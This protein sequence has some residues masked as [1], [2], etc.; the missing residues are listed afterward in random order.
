MNPPFYQ[1]RF[2]LIAA[3][4]FILL[5]GATNPRVRA[6]EI[7]DAKKALAKG[8]YAEAAKL[9]LTAIEQ[10]QY[11]EEPRVV[12]ASALLAVGKYP[13]AQAA[14]SNALTRIHSG[15]RVRLTG[16]EVYRQNGDTNRANELLREINQ[17]AGSRSWAY[18]DPANF[19]ALGRAALLLGADPKVVLEKV[20]DQAKKI[21]ASFR[22]TYLASGELALDKHDYE[23]AAKTFDEAL[24]KFPQDAELLFGL[25][26]AYE[27]SNR[28][29]MLKA[30]TSALD[31]NPR[32]VPSLLLIVEHMID[33]ENYDE[34]LKKLDEIFKINPWQPDAWA[35]ASVI[36]HLRSDAPGEKDSRDKALKFW[37][38]NPRVENLIGKK[39]SQKY[40]FAEGAAHQRQ[41]LKFDDDFVPARIQLAQDLLRL[42]DEA[43]GWKLVKEASDADAY[44]VETFNLLT[45]KDSIAKFASVTNENF[46]IR[47]TRHEADIYGARALA[48]LSRARTN[49]SAKYGL[50]LT[51]P[52]IVEIFPSQ[53]DFGVRTFGMP[54]NPGY[55]GVCFGRVITANSPASQGGHPA[56]W[57]A[58]L[59]HE[60]CHVIT[61]TLTKNKMPRWLSEGI[62]VYEE[63]Q[64]NPAWG[65]KMTA[66]FR[67]IIL[68]GK[69]KPIGE[70]SAAFLTAKSNQQLQFAYFESSLAVE[71]LVKKFGAEAI[72]KILV[73]L[74]NGVEINQAI[75]KNTA[76]L[77]NT[78][79]EFADFL[80]E[81]ADQL[82]PGLD[83]E[84]P[85]RAELRGDGLDLP[86]I[87][88]LDDSDSP[89]KSKE[90]DRYGNGP[91]LTIPK[92]GLSPA[93]T[94][95][96]KQHP[97]NFYAL[98]LQADQL[99][100]DKKLAEAKQ[101]LN[102][103]IELYP[104]H[105]GPNNAYTLLADIH[106]ELNETNAEREVLSRLAVL[107]ADAADTFLRLMDLGAGAKNWDL[108]S[109][110]AERFIAVNPLV[111]RPYRYL[112][113]A[114]EEL[115]NPPAAIYAYQTLLRL[116]PNDPAEIHFHL[117]KLLHGRDEAA[118]RR[119]ILQTLEEAPRFRDGH[120][121]LLEIEKAAPAP[122]SATNGFPLF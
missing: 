36:R 109:T 8:N 75:E 99:L 32:H 23:L 48:L 1:I 98:N 53:K 26:R 59:W 67:E 77:K 14:V 110:N 120:R 91:A 15:I 72:H 39:L 13:E 21:D 43:E 40:R 29:L 90:E 112:G 118:A 25:A 92:S 64:A 28:E 42:G 30:I 58:V 81:Q 31:E 111:P 35:F 69:M 65:Q 105:V 24:K 37:K 63:S 44:D 52:T 108:V 71:F 57:E 96:I 68:A 66:D 56:N 117:A 114:A 121:L 41:A 18:R 47:M 10:N 122:A 82:A 61:L 54:D 33:S 46:I 34:A 104:G 70:L 97:T 89:P 38:N 16:F 3:A 11:D 78:E 95:W 106:R 76:P 2:R 27:P 5:L 84:K 116:D 102:K 85:K 93:M 80:H 50:T 88:G 51:E 19:I 74:G 4:A 94:A 6:D 119:H 49:L 60:F 7:D 17:L 9:S 100:K 87:P 107:E 101:P 12:L 45:L 103:L 86:K 113:Q 73:D 79:K 20:Y 62:S 55:L 83:W 115:K 22:D